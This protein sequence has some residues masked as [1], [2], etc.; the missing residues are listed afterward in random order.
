MPILF[1]DKISFSSDAIETKKV[2]SVNEN[3]IEVLIDNINGD[4]NIVEFEKPIFSNYKKDDSI[5]I[6]MNKEICY[7]NYKTAGN[8]CIII[9]CIYTIILNIFSLL[10][11]YGEGTKFFL[12]IMT[13]LDSIFLL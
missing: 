4:P 8:I 1:Y 11:S 7:F 3:T 6:C 10:Y 5:L 12:I 9:I 13:T 2:W